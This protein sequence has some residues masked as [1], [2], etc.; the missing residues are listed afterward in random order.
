MKIWA[1]G[2]VFYVSYTFSPLRTICGGSFYLYSP[3]DTLCVLLTR[4]VNGEE[5]IHRLRESAE[6]VVCL[7]SPLWGKAVYPKDQPG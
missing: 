6:E 4:V 1:I 7:F 5:T 2:S 3:R